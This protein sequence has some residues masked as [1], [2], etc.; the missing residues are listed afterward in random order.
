MQ[1]D[2]KHTQ[3]RIHT[4]K[5]IVY[6]DEFVCSTRNCTY[7]ISYKL[8]HR[9]HP[10]VALS[11]EVENIALLNWT[12]PNGLSSMHSPKEHISIEKYVRQLVISH[13]S[14]QRNWKKGGSTD[15]W[16]RQNTIIN[17]WQHRN[18]GHSSSISLFAS[19]IVYHSIF[20][21]LAS[22]ID[23]QAMPAVHI[24]SAV[25]VTICPARHRLRM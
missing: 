17:E 16:L 2:T 18:Q 6:N 24:W 5:Y 14:W 8:F 7:R 21:K 11:F 4:H 10:P 22:F 20:W 3:H 1:S 13:V 15:G 12:F 23:W 19:Q 25:T 9:L